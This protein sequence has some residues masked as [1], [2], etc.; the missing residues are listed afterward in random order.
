M[1]KNFIKNVLS[2]IRFIIM[3]ILVVLVFHHN[4]ALQAAVP[5]G[6]MVPTVEIGNHVFINCLTY[7][8]NAP[9]QGD[10]IA[11]YHQEEDKLLPTR[12]LKRIIAGPND[13]IDIRDNV[14]YIN[15]I[16]LDESDY[17]SSD[18][19]TYPYYFEFPYTLPNNQYFVMGDN[20]ENSGDSRFWGPVDRKDILGKAEYVIFPFDDI[21]KLN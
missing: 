12:Y 16:P 2:E 19:N 20:R 18:V 8:F 4:I 11:F 10:I 6:S 9:E 21:H 1:K 7:K 3:T 13:T 17:L 5:T 14:I 15:D